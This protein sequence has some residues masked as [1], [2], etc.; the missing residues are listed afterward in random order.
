MTDRAYGKFD[1]DVSAFRIQ[2]FGQYLNDCLNLHVISK[3]TKALKFFKCKTLKDESF[4]EQ[5]AGKSIMS[6]IR[7]VTGS[8]NCLKLSQPESST[9]SVQFTRA[10]IRQ[11][12]PVITRIKI[13]SR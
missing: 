6:S 3:D 12:D 8:S 10:S 5:K 7:L 2:R 9:A 13:L 4:L 11:I 1:I